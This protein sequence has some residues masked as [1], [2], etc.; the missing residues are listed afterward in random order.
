MVVA[1]TFH[2]VAG[3]EFY[4]I[5]F[6]KIKN[7]RFRQYGRRNIQRLTNIRQVIEKM[8]IRQ[9]FGIFV[10]GLFADFAVRHQ[11][12]PNS[13]TPYYTLMREK[14]KPFEAKF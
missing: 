1:Q 4:V 10:Y 14:S 8:R 3:N 9:L 7:V 2:K 11:L 5:E 13:H 6:G 12:C